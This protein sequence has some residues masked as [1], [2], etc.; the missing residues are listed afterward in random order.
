MI[1]EDPSTHYVEQH[2]CVV[3][4]GNVFLGCALEPVRRA[5]DPRQLI[6]T[7]VDR[8]RDFGRDGVRV[9]QFVPQARHVCLRLFDVGDNLPTLQFQRPELQ[10]CVD[11]IRATRSPNQRLLLYAATA[12]KCFQLAGRQQRLASRQP[13]GKHRVGAQ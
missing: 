4:R 6:R 10:L 5:D 2:V 11:E 9:L 7:L 8:G 13:E 3:M 12:A 1:G